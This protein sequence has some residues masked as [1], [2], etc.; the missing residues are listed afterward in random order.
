MDQGLS[1]RLVCPPQGPRAE[2]MMNSAMEQG[3]WV[4]F[5]NCHLAP[6]WM[7]SLERLVEGIDA[8]KVS[9]FTEQPACLEV[10]RQEAGALGGAQIEFCPTHRFPVQPE[11]GCRSSCSGCACIL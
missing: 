4:F 10:D 1:A 11:D 9:S 8:S 7:P 5:Q 2:A 6:S 3:N